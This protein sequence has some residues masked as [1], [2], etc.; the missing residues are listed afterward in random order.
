MNPQPTQHYASII[1]NIDINATEA[2]FLIYAKFITWG[3]Y[4]KDGKD[5]LKYVTIE[6][7]DTEHLENVLI[8]QDCLH[9]ALRKIMICLLRKRYANT[10]TNTK[11]VTIQSCSLNLIPV[12]N[13]EPTLI[14]RLKSIQPRD[15][16]YLEFLYHAIVRQLEYKVNGVIEIVYEFDHGFAYAT[17]IFQRRIMVWPQKMDF[18]TLCKHFI[19]S[20]Y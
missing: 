19:D 9:P 4:G 17:V 6:L 15:N 1:N 5:P 16:K 20:T 2:E 10:K 11:A 13:I 18:S 14:D 12:T 3:T 8:T 7:M